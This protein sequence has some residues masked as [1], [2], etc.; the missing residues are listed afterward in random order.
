MFANPMNLKTL[1]NDRSGVAAIEY[2]LI[3]SLMCVI[4]ITVFPMLNTALTGAIKL[5]AGHLTTGI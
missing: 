2:A 3:A 5:I 1:T 4:L